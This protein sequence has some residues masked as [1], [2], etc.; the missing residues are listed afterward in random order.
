M[1]RMFVSYEIRALRV[2]SAYIVENKAS[3]YAEDC[4]YQTLTASSSLFSHP[5]SVRSSHLTCLCPSKHRDAHCVL[6][7]VK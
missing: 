5:R 3:S 2:V 6:A 4:V 7:R 1:S